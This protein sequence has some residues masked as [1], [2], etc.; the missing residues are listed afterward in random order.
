MFSKLKG[1]SIVSGIKWF[2]LLVL[3]AAGTLFVDDFD[4]LKILQKPADIRGVASSDLNE[5]VGKYVSMD[6]LEVLNYYA[7]T[8]DSDGNVISEELVI[9]TPDQ[10][11]LMA[12]VVTSSDLDKLEDAIY[13]LARHNGAA[14]NTPIIPIQGTLAQMD[15]ESIRYFDEFLSE[16]NIDSGVAAYYYLQ[17]NQ[18]GSLP[19]HRAWIM[20]GIA[21]GM[22]LLGLL[23]IVYAIAGMGQ[24]AIKAYYRKAENGD[25]EYAKQK[26]EQEWEQGEDLKYARMTPNFIIHQ[27]GLSTKLVETKNIAWAYQ[28]TT[29]RNGVPVSYELMLGMVSPKKRMISI[30]LSGKT[31]EQALDYVLYHYNWVALGYNPNLQN[32]YTTQ[33]EALLPIAQQQRQPA[34]AQEA[35]PVAPPYPQAPESLPPTNADNTPGTP[36]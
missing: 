17:V 5:Y 9:T 25:S 28:K 35:A 24:R 16:E 22:V 19:M 31:I 11:A 3:I 15:S 36:L 13:R 7:Y 14:A 23:L 4:A 21:G 30:S 33:P 29:R 10:T 2:I 27:K 8:E 34:P 18:V 32:I 6:V 1:K 20:L 12:I 26:L